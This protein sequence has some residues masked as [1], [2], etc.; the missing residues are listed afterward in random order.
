MQNAT[1]HAVHE[2]DLENA[3]GSVLIRDDL[4]REVGED[5]EQRGPRWLVLTCG[6]VYEALPPEVQS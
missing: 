2:I 1:T 6:R 4:A 5:V 3:G